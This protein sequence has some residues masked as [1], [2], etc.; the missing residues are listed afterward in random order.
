MFETDPKKQVKRIATI[1]ISLALAGLIF[2]AMAVT[3]FLILVPV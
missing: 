2:V 1:A 3:L